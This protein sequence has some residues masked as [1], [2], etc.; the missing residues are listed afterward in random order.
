MGFYLPLVTHLLPPS[1]L[2]PNTYFET[3]SPA[4]LGG[5]GTKIGIVFITVLLVTS[6][7]VIYTIQ[8]LGKNLVI[9]Q[10]LENMR[11]KGNRM[12]NNLD[13]VTE[14]IEVLTTTVASG[15]VPFIQHNANAQKPAPDNGQSLNDYIYQIYNRLE[16][17]K[18]NGFGIYPEKEAFKTPIDMGLYWYRPQPDKPYILYT[19]PPE[20][21]DVTSDFWY[22]PAKVLY[23]QA[24]IT[25]CIWTESY[26]EPTNKTPMVTCTAPVTDNQTLLGATQVDV[27][28][29]EIDGLLQ[30]WQKDFNGYMLLIDNNNRILSFPNLTPE[31]LKTMTLTNEGVKT[32]NTYRYELANITLS[33]LV[34]NYPQFADIQTAVNDVN[35][36][37]IEQARTT[38]NQGNPGQGKFDII[39]Q[40]MINRSQGLIKADEAER[41]VAFSL[42][43]QAVDSQNKLIDKNSNFLQK[44]FLLADDKFL[45]SPSNV[46]LFNVPNTHWNLVVVQPEYETTKTADTLAKTLLAYLIPAILLGIFLISLFVRKLIT[47]RLVQTSKQMYKIQL[48]ISQNNHHHLHKFALPT[49]GGDEISYLNTSINSLIKRVQDNEGVL[50]SLY[51]DL[52]EKVEERTQDLQNALQDLTSSQVQLIRAEKMATLGQMVAGVAHEVNTPLSYVQNNLELIHVLLHD[53]DE[54]NFRLYALK[55]LMENGNATGWEVFYQLEQILPLIE[56]ID[57][58]EVQ[59]ELE[60][61]IKD[62][63]FGVE[64]I[65]DLVS[66]LRNFSRID[67]SKIKQVDILECINACL[68]MLK[69]KLKMVTL[70]TDYGA[71][72]PIVCSPSQINQVIMNILSNACHAVLRQ[73][74]LIDP[75]SRQPFRPKIG[76]RTFASDDWLTIEITDNGT[77]MDARTLEQIFEP[78]FTTKS[79]GE[80]TGLGMAISQQIITQHGGRIDVLSEPNKGTTFSIKLPIKSPLTLV[81][82]ITSP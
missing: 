58:L 20:G 43:N 76:I 39:I 46:M 8:T 41:I 21:Y 45:N 47:Q 18:I 16:D 7:L 38:L 30:T 79:A 34:A 12:V 4:P 35:K 52:E 26:V 19:N 66:N 25:D 42:N 32:Y 11:E 75:H 50:A 40:E 56:K 65:S 48:A 70:Y 2:M 59:E 62:S 27:S 10:S 69:N 6:S 77:G 33:D 36:K 31:R 3:T 54:L 72:P 82:E 17:K 51:S 64:Q 80:G 44:Q 37:L 74:K 53:Y 73:K 15:A 23:Q 81:K 78:F 60:Q 14:Q 71:T 49:T 68:V 29:A 55:M 22:V 28:L 1:A 13:D 5:L 67:E 57:P 63:L 24:G 9:N 61:M